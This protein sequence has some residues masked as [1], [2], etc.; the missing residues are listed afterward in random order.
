MERK[1]GFKHQGNR[2]KLIEL[3]RNKGISD[4]K[5]LEAMNS[6]P[7]HFFLNSA[8]EDHAYED[9]AFPIEANQTISHPYTVAF[10]SE[11]LHVQ[12]GDKILEVGTGSGYQ[13]AVLVA[14][15]AKVY[16]IERQK[17]LVD[18]SRKMLN[19]LNLQPQYQTFGDG[20]KGLPTFAPFDK[21]IVTAGSPRIPSVL[22]QQLKIGGLAVVPI[23]DV[24]QKMY[25]F[26]RIDEQKYEQMEFGDYQFVPM[27]ERKDTED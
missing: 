16:T 14:M 15:D 26:L 17:A 10:Q 11:L 5:V 6:I 1:D 19:A 2:R 12:P 18:F 8:F 7:R 3:L 13:T 4:E 25:T 23:G 20:Y 24:N 27:L 9:K 21:I 22:L